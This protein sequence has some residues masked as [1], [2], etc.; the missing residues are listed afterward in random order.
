MLVFEALFRKMNC[1]TLF[2]YNFYQ[3]IDIIFHNIFIEEVEVKA[4]EQQII[5]LW[6]ENSIIK[7]TVD[8]RNEQKANALSFPLD[9]SLLAI[10]EW[11]LD[12]ELTMKVH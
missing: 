4:L 3:K 10:N 5:Y 8:E 6:I 11:T 12:L 7:H 1:N 2:S 9:S